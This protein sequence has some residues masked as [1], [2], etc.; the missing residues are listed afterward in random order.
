[1]LWQ[2]AGIVICSRKGSRKPKVLANQIEA[3][4]RV[5][6]IASAEK[7]FFANHHV[8]LQA[9]LHILVEMGKF[10]GENSQVIDMVAF[11]SA[12]LGCATY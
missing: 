4:A 5:F 8:F 9:I 6:A 11:I 12:L 7:D 1:M 3:Q 2:A 10:S